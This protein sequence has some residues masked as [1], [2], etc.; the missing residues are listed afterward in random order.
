MI[1][2]AFAAAEFQFFIGL[3]SHQST[4]HGGGN[5]DQSIKVDIRPW[6][7]DDLP[8]LERLMGDPAMTEHLGGPET[9]EKI[10]DRHT[11][12]WKPE[13]PGKVRMFVIMVGA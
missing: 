1:P 5:S 13:D 8:L 7:A 12:Y 4:N 10:R 2:I 9:P 3:M 11:R 6:S